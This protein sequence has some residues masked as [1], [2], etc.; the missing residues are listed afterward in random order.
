LTARPAAD[1]RA[2]LLA[3]LADF[4][5]RH[6]PRG[7]LRGD[8]AEPAPES[9]ML[10]VA[11]SWSVTFRRWVMPEEAARETVPR[12]SGGFEE[13]IRFVETQRE[14]MPA[15]CEIGNDLR[16]RGNPHIRADTSQAVRPVN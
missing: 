8:A 13:L 7:Q 5:T 12:H 10:G 11:C 1:P 2:I 14:Q 16:C 9:Y 3:E 15:V 4:V 6:R